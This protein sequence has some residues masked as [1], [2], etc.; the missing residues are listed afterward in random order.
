MSRAPF[1]LAVAL[2]A[3]ALPLGAAGALLPEL[4]GSWRLVSYE[5]RDATGNAVHPYGDAPAGRLTYDATGHMAVQVMKTPPPE[6]TGDDADRFTVEQKVALFDGY[7]AYF[8]RYEVDR[9]RKIVTH[10]PEAHLS[11]LYI[12][13]REE[14][15]YELT[16]DRL[17]LSE[18]WT[19][20]GKTWSGVRVFERIR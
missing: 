3:L 1:P 6:V 10:L 17:V 15:H 13:R 16:G 18:T 12:G 5:D 14:R 11:R 9:R 20:G 2:V 19:Q 7:A 8:G 4:V